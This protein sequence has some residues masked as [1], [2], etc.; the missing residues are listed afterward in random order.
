M[1]RSG[2]LTYH[3]AS[4]QDLC[5]QA[6]EREAE[7]MSATYAAH[8]EDVSTIDGLLDALVD[9]IHGGGDHDDWAISYELYLA[10]LR[11][12]ELRTSPRRGCRP[13]GGCS[14]NISTR[15]RRGWSTASSKA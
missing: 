5:R 3:F 12:P 7:Q 14:S 10:A 15:R 4:L 11:D 2:S 8:F 1:F 13:A 6:F 9:L